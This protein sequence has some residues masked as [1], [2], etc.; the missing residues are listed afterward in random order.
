M[1]LIGNLR[2][3]CCALIIGALSFALLAAGVA[4]GADQPAAKASRPPNIIFILVDDYGWTDL[5]CY[6]SKFYETPNIDRLAGEGMRFTNAYAACTVCSPTRAAVMT[7]KYPARL[8]VTDWIAG[9]NRPNA[10]LKIPDWT[11]HLPLEET[12]IAE[13]LKPAGY[14]TASIGKWHLGGEGFEPTRQGFDVNIGGTHMGQPPS[15][16]FPYS[17]RA[18]NKKRPAVNLPGLEEGQAGEYLTD[19]LGDEAIKFITEN[20]DRPFYIYLP[21]YAVHTPLQAKQ[22]MVAKFQAKADPQAPQHNPT[23]AAMIESMDQSVGRIM[24]HLAALNLA[25]NTIVVFTGDNGG[26]VLNQVTSNVPLRAGKGSAYEGGVRVPLIVRYPPLVKAG[27]TCDEP[28]ISVDYFPTLVELAGAKSV[29]QADKKPAVDGVS[30]ARL[31]KDSDAT[32]GR[33]AIYWHYPHYHP[34]GATP[35]SAIRAGDFRLVEFFEDDHVE[36]YN[37]KDDLS[38]TTDLAAKLPA[39]RD[40]LHQKLQAWRDSVGAQYPTA[41]PAY[42]P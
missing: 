29:K 3:F 39:K 25:D 24:A 26:L 32:L 33:E 22:E 11:L 6:G 42:K 27:T 1:N 15:Y 21:H 19:R 9:H 12:T 18:N 17:K 35:Y 13:A 38:E 7:G 10:K 14:T 36:L 2:A 23:Y 20:K 34:G 8:H 40:E 28:V 16:F 41:N 4:H 37:L 5:S 31:L 30:I